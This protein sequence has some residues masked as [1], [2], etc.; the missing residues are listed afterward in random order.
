MLQLDATSFDSYAIAQ[1]L[2]AAALVVGLLVWAFQGSLSRNVKNIDNDVT[3]AKDKAEKIATQSQ[4]SYD[5]LKI[6]IDRMQVSFDIF[7]EKV[8]NDKF[9]T[10]NNIHA[11]TQKIT[12]DL[13]KLNVSLAEIKSNV[14]NTSK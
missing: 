9:I 12:E 2:A 10:Q 7:K 5:E 4:K 6:I 14:N 8:E 11:L 3:E 1:L 13:N